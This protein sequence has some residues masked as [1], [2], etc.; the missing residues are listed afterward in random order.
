LQTIQEY[1]VLNKSHSLV[2]NPNPQIFQESL[3]EIHTE[4]FSDKD[5]AREN[6]QVVESHNDLQI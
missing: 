6:K 3:N 5:C 1:E 4:D 2:I